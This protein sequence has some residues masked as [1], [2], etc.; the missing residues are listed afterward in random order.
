M[1]NIF[2]QLS[3]IIQR[4]TLGQ[5]IIIATLVIGM[6]SSMVSLV[7]WANRPEYEV[8]FTDMDP[9]VASKMVG[10]LQGSKVEYKLENR[11][12]TLLVP[13][14]N[15]S[16]WRLRFTELG[17]V[18]DIVNGY[19]IFDNNDIGMTSFKQK[20][21]MRR[22]LEGELTR[23]INQFPSV[24]NSRVHLAIPE[25]KLFQDEKTGKASV[26]LY[27][28]PGAYL[29][30]AQIKGINAL[31]ANSVEEIEPDAVVVI[32]S[33]GNLLSDN[34][35]EQAIM[36]TTGSQWDL[37][38]AVESTIQKKVQDILDGVLGYQNSVVKVAA[39]LNFEQLERTTEA[40]DT[41]NVAILSEE[42]N[43]ET[44]LGADSAEYAKE[45]V[46]TNYELNKTTEHYVAPSGDLQRL[47]VAVLVN[48]RYTKAVDSD[49]NE[50][51]EYIPRS[52]KELSQIATLVKSAVGF[53]E[54]RGDLVQ[55]ENI[56]FDKSAVEDDLAYFEEVESKAIWAE[57]INKGI[58]FISI[59]VAFFF[60]KSMLKKAGVDEGEN[61]KTPLLNMSPGTI[62]SSTYQS[63]SQQYA[64]GKI[65]APLEQEIDEDIYVRKLSPEARAKIK[66]K[67]KM[68]TS[69][70]T[71]AEKSPDQAAKL[72]R[73]WVTQ[74][75]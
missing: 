26:V 74:P 58:L 50:T 37:K 52:S 33:D 3:Q 2:F 10:D 18:G 7:M 68:T 30:R 46:I 16:E 43:N 40:Y 12:R 57:I 39:D 47:T 44:S 75:G 28:T 59:L 32:D 31:V 51:K 63:A 25:G 27:L 23:T 5:R 56:Q 67:D 65:M 11:G 22:A 20:I 73:S 69:V 13:K 64:P 21:N 62:P 4:Y 72:V 29:D 54:E 24:L 60:V 55:V 9:T 35:G 45:N 36:G 66:A 70:V 61:M 48:G 15:I 1:N 6:I 14:E 42:R 41:E 71:H 53:N 19:E 49:G 34:Q 8:L 38:V 17:Y